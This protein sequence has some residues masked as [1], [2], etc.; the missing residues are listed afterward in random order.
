MAVAAAVVS[1][2]S[3]GTPKGSSQG[4]SSAFLVATRLSAPRGSPWAAAVPAFGEPK[5]MVVWH[6]I[7]VGLS[8]SFARSMAS[9][10]LRQQLP[11][12]TSMTF[13]P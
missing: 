6:T 7:R 12:A 9:F 5:P 4:H 3:A 13:Q 10:T 1:Y 2:T 8:E 11:L